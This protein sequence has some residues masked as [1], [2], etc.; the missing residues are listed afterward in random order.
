MQ[1]AVVQIRSLGRCIKPSGLQM[2]DIDQAA[3]LHPRLAATQS[4]R[5][6]FS[7]LVLLSL[8]D[9]LRH[10]DPST[11]VSYHPAVTP[12]SL[13]EHS[14]LPWQISERYDEANG[15]PCY[16]ALKK[17]LQEAMQSAL[18]TRARTEKTAR[19]AA[20]HRDSSSQRSCPTMLG[21]NHRNCLHIS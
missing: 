1:S 4:N 13:R 17:A 10:Q 2:Q 5:F 12:S 3:A 7:D 9:R 8:N 16:R 11:I 21:L 15:G 14:D 20:E 19:N 18:C 6:P